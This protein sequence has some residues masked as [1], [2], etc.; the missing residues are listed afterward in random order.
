MRTAV[1]LGLLI[2]AAP[3]AAAAAPPK[4]VI[5]KTLPRS[6]FG[7]SYFKSTDEFLTWTQNYYRNPRPDMLDEAFRFFLDSELSRDEIKR[8]EIA[9]FFGA[10]LAELPAMAPAVRDAALRDRSYESLFAL[11]NALW[12]ADNDDCRAILRELAEKESNEQ[13]KRFINRRVQTVSPFATD[14]PIETLGEMRMRWAQFGA[15]GDIAIPEQ[16]S[17]IVLTQ[18]ETSPEAEIFQDTAEQSIRARADRP[19]VLEGLR[20][21]IEKA[22][23]SPRREKAVELYEELAGQL[24]GPAPAP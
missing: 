5:P 24:P 9:A 21:A 20:R 16:I 8:I 15:T 4:P 13:V 12:L 7:L 1:L 2:A 23:P 18:Y 19:E 22:Q 17:A 14:K 6:S 10:A 11:V 3:L